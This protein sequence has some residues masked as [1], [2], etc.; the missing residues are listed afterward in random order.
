MQEH[1]GGGQH[2]PHADEK[3]SV[4]MWTRL[5]RLPGRLRCPIM[6]PVTGAT[7]QAPAVWRRLEPAVGLPEIVVGRHGVGL[8]VSGTVGAVRGERFS[9]CLAAQL[10]WQVPP[11]ESLATPRPNGAAASSGLAQR[12]RSIEQTGGPGRL[13]RRLRTDGVG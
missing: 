8:L 7:Q 12:C 11:D 6:L 10:G 4:L 9:G 1:P 3:V 13:G 2:R 5:T